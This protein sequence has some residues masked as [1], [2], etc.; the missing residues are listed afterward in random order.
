MLVRITR[1]P[2]QDSVD[3]I[4]LS[5]FKVGLTYSLPVSLATLMIAEGW[6]VPVAESD[7]IT[8]P[9]IKLQV[10]PARDRRRRTLTDYR[11]RVELGI[12]ADRRRKPKP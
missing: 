5:A 6:A 3:G 1:Q 12:A 9:E 8:L 7:D 10:F 4:S 2:N 11:L